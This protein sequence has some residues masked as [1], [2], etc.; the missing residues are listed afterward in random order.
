MR[1]TTTLVLLL[2]VVITDVSLPS[3]LGTIPGPECHVDCSFGL[4]AFFH[5]WS[6][7]PYFY[8]ESSADFFGAACL[9]ALIVIVTSTAL[10]CRRTRSTA[11]TADVEPLQEP[12]HIRFMSRNPKEHISF[13]TTCTT[14]ASFA[15]FVHL[16]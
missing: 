16:F 11:Q 7:Y 15:V 4:V 8:G 6:H 9:R 12:L 10:C 14:R 5:V 3:T 13:D 1:R 2:V